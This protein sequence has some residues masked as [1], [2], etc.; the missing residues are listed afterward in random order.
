MFE[1]KDPESPLY[2]AMCLG[3][4]GFQIASK[5]TADGRDWDWSTFGNA[6][7]FFADLIVAGTMLDRQDTIGGELIFPGV[8]GGRERL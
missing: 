8:R 3:T 1:D 2:G 6:N 5:R 7:G 4:Q